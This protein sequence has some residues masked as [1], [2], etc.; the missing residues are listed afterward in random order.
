MEDELPQAVSDGMEN[1][2]CQHFLSLIEHL[3]N[4][5]AQMT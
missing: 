1:L 2:E 5:F 3:A 4:S